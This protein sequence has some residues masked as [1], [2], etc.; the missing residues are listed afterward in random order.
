MNINF[1][2][3]ILQNIIFKNIHDIIHLLIQF[4]DLN[5]HTICMVFYT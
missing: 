2:N 4:S 5:E 1:K 3:N